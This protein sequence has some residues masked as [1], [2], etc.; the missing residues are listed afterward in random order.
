MSSTLQEAHRR[1]RYRAAL[2][3]I[4]IGK[5]VMKLGFRVTDA[6]EEITRLGAV[7]RKANQ[8]LPKP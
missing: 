7:A 3:L 8:E 6:G 4:E 2:V 5:A 1:V